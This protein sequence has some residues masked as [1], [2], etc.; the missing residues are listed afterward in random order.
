MIAIVDSGST[1]GDW[2]IIDDRKGITIK[3]STIGLNPYFINTDDVIKELKK[4][5][6]LQKISKYL[7]HIFFYGAGCSSFEN[8]NII[9]KGLDVMFPNSINH[10]RHDLLAAAYACYETEPIIVCILGTGSNSCFFDGNKIR[11]ETPSLSFI[12]GDEGSGSSFGKKLIKSFFL[13]KMPKKIYDKFKTTFNLTNKELNKNIYHNPFANTYL[14][15][16][17]KFILLHK[18]EPF[19]Q[20]IIYDSLNEF[21]ENQILIYPETG[22]VKL[23]FVGSIAYYYKDI[24]TSV[25]S[26]YHLSIGK[27]IRKPINNLV[28]YHITNINKIIS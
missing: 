26:K 4:N 21:I 13:K 8:N 14:A 12:L 1:K 19:I 25:T 3:T 27:I 20:K 2:V 5:T 15:S 28:E 6:T 9:K 10:V 24:L 22:Y 11:E 17:S 7:T 16:F 18:K 23:N